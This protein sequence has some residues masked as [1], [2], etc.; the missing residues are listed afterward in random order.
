MSKEKNYRSLKAI[1]GWSSF[2]LLL[3]GGCGGGDYLSEAEMERV[4]VT[5]RIK[6]TEDA[7]GL[8]LIV[9][10]EAITS[11]EILN[12]RV[13]HRGRV[14][15]LKDKPFEQ[16]GDSE[17]FKEQ[18]KPDVEKI[19]STEIS[20][21]LLYQ[22]AMR[23]A[24]GDVNA[25]L[26]K[27]AQ[28]E[29]RKFVLSFGGDQA[30]A[31][32]ALKEMGLDRRGYMEEQKRL[33]LV[34]QYATSKLSRNK[35]VTY[36]ELR[37]GYDRMKDELFAIKASLRFRLIDVD[38]ARVKIADPNQDPF[39]L[40]D[41]LFLEMGKSQDDDFGKL[42]EKHTGVFFID[43]SKGVQPESLVEPYDILV[44]GADKIKP[45]EITKPMVKDE[46]I[47]I[48]KLL[49]NRNEGYEPFARV[50]REV[51][52]KIIEER[53]NKVLNRINE[54]LL[55]QAELSETDKFVDFC[56]DKLYEM[57]SR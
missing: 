31:D 35:P 30:R 55:Q 29:F 10:G 28:K 41:K 36:R 1:L 3:I 32:Q 11:D 23:Q 53:Q 25:A 13:E 2:V 49:E 34:R 8:V 17:K 44:L 56:L 57:R 15:L 24:G 50:Q 37:A 20:D 48:M 42:A 27:A 52:K 46:H 40:A 45:G 16:M 47:L 22:L 33:I 4:A 54:K 43:H 6:L 39:E 18:A 19:L 21:I 9:G 38:I 7:G 26:D 51:E 12:S 5:E 14:V